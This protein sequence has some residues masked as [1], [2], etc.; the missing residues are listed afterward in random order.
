MGP[1]SRVCEASWKLD[2]AGD[3]QHK[4]GGGGGG[5]EGG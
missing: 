1:W 4:G 5:A 2:G 3:I